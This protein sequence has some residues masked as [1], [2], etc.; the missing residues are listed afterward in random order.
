MC[1][2]SALR[3][4]RPKLKYARNRH[5]SPPH[6]SRHVAHVEPNMSDSSSHPRA[7][8]FEEY[9]EEAHTTLPETRQ[10]AN[11]AAKRS[12]PDIAKVKTAQDGPDDA[13]DSGHNS[14]PP[15]HEE[16]ERISHEPK[17]A[18]PPPLKIDVTARA[19]KSKPRDAKAKSSGSPKKAQKPA[20]RRT[21]SKA[22]DGPRPA[23][24]EGCNCSE[25]QA[26]G[27]R[28]T[29]TRKDSRPV[30][31]RGAPPSS[32]SKPEA[33]VPSSPVYTARPQ[34]IQIPIVQPAQA[35][36]RSATT[37]TYRSARPM[38]FHAGAMP[39]HLYMQPPVYMTGLSYP[40][41]SVTP[42]KPTYFLPSFPM[43]PP[44][45]NMPSV[46][47]FPSEPAPLPPLL[48]GRPHPGQWIPEPLA[49]LRQ[50][51]QYGTSPVTE[52][53]G[54]SVYLMG[55]PNTQPSPRWSFS[56][57]E[58]PVDLHKGS[59]LRNEDYF[60]MPP[61]PRPHTTSHQ[62]RPTFRQ[63]ASTS[64]MPPTLHYTR[65]RRG[66]ENAI[67]VRR[68]RS[69]R[70]ASPEKRELTSRPSLPSRSSGAS[71][72]S[73][74]TNGLAPDRN[75]ARVRVESNTAA[76]QNRRVSYYGH[77][78]H[79]DLERVAEEYQALSMADVQHRAPNF[80]ADSLKLVR[81]KTHNSDTGS[82]ISADGKR[83]REGSEVKPRSSTD[84]R[85][86]SDV[87]SRSDPEDFTIRFPQGVNVDLGEGVEGRTI[88]LRPSAEGEGG[89]ELSIGGARDR[90][91]G[92]GNEPSDRSRKRNSYV[93]HS[94]TKEVEYARS[95]SRIPRAD[96]DA[97]L[98]LE[99]ERRM[100]G[101]RS[102]RSSRTGHRESRG[103]F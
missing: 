78:S 17:M 21:E 81:K 103:F 83:S 34:P 28:P 92:G 16:S 2:A 39:E 102:R 66:E 7:A 8:Y 59:L 5:P 58:R 60:Q 25:C 9:N 38:S 35:R 73:D 71:G 19:S 97:E 96:R 32:R 51:I 100:A 10:T 3:R 50:P 76:K 26:G 95:V 65:S 57:G 12:K 47:S 24:K 37:Q 88:S 67:G 72:H 27:K 29:T 1:L 61:P 54:R 82:R 87:K 90:S 23:S 15:I 64:A 79:K 75:P 89:M 94:G 98:T 84:R 74:R 99:R 18:N 6:P 4:S 31:D 69:P 62:H 86:G 20:L 80:A 101:S 91:T 55:N 46:S 33:P 48:H 44:R 52:H 14:A 43:R 53:P 93:D 40:P 30:E 41:P 45:P 77:E 68:E 63:V 36:P 22:Q 13:S 11:V 49:H 70:K 42:P 85:G 56:Q